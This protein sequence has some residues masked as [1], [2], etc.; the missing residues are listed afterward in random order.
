MEPFADKWRSFRWEVIT[1][2][3]HDMN[4]ILS[5]LD[6]ARSVTRSPVVIIARTVKGKGV[7]FMENKA[8]WHG[9]PPDKE[10]YEAAMAELSGEGS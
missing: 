9:I 1:I 7:S 4:Q 6:E 2:D 5:A 3:G 10:Q 8:Q